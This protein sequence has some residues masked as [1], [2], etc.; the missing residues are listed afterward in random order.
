MKYPSL[1][2][3]LLF[4]LQAV[5]TAQTRRARSRPAA[6]AA[7]SEPAAPVAAAEADASRLPAGYVGHS[8]AVVFSAA[9]KGSEVIAYAFPA[10]KA[11][12]N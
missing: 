5:G 8:P 11:I 1:L 4:T 3:C 6:R 10:Q 12:Q 7:S 2:L 9:L